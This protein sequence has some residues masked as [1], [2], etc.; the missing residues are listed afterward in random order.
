MRCSRCGGRFILWLLDCTP[1]VLVDW[2][3]RYY[4]GGNRVSRIAPMDTMGAAAA[5]K[6]MS[7]FKLAGQ[8][9]FCLRPL[10]DRLD[11]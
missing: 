2:M 6:V 1:P 11:D 10:H 9:Q 7:V 3:G 4:R 8:Y 5:R